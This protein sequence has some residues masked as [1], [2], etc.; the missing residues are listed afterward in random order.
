MRHMTRRTWNTWITKDTCVFVSA[1]ALV[2]SRL[3]LP[4]SSSL[5]LSLPFSLPLDRRQDEDRARDPDA[6]SL[7]NR[8]TTQTSGGGIGITFYLMRG[9]RVESKGKSLLIGCLFH[10]VLGVCVCVWCVC[11]CVS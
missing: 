7:A 3:V 10:C 1:L 4:S 6:R 9:A 11:V 2:S 5:P 8:R